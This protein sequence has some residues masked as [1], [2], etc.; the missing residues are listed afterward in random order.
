MGEKMDSYVAQWKNAA[1]S[2]AFEDPMPQYD[3]SAKA[4][5]QSLTGGTGTAVKTQADQQR[6]TASKSFTM[7]GTAYPI[8]ADGTFTYKGQ[9]Y[10]PTPDGKNATRVP[11]VPQK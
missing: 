9:K 4:A 8:G 3:D 1:P 7:G 5:R 10:K 2:P 6:D 11:A